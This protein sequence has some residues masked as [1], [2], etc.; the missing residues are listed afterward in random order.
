MKCEFRVGERYKLAH[1]TTKYTYTFIVLDK[2]T[3]SVDQEKVLLEF[4]IIGI[5][6]ESLSFKIGH[7]VKFTYSTKFINDSDNWV[8]TKINTL[9]EELF[10]L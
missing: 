9:P 7:V 6:P 2:F 5:P 10:I 1:T 4:T 3:N 8:I